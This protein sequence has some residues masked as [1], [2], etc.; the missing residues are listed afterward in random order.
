MKQIY[1]KI[2]EL[3]KPYYKKGRPM[4]ID[5]IEWMMQDASLVC[6]EENLDDSLLLP[7]VI[8]HDVGYAEVPKDNPFKLNLRK[9]HM[10]AGANISKRI[11]EKLNYPIEKTQKIE[12]YVSVHDNWALGIND[13]YNEDKILGTFNDLDYMWM[14]TPKGF[15]ALMKILEKNEQKMLEHLE[16]DEKP[17]L[18]PFSTNTTKNLYEKYMDDRRKD[19]QGV[20][21]VRGLIESLK[22]I[23]MR[24]AS[25]ND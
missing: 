6:Q 24:A 4:D 17:K 7:L 19:V 14:A 1:T 13:I 11:L 16:T 18:R 20:L 5:H 15:S 23:R 2:W 3:A 10:E 12:Y 8:L 25:L 9:V 21:N 22:A